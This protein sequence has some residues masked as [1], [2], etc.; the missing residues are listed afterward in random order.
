MGAAGQGQQGQQKHQNAHAADPVGEAAPK[1][2][3]LGQIRHSGQD[4]RAGGGKA[5]NGLKQRIHRVRDAAGQHKGHSTHHT[6]EQPAQRRGHKAFPHVEDLALGLDA[7]EHRPR[8]R[9]E[10]RRE[11]EHAH[12][13]PLAVAQAGDG[14][15]QQQSALRQQD[16][17]QQP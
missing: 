10:G 6:D 7:V 5:G 15:Q 1:Q 16:V 3:A 8:Q 4:G 12:H 2:N 9:A 14:G 17:A 11:Q 13:E